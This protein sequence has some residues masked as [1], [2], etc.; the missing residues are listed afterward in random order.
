MSGDIQKEQ[1]PGWG[2][3]L[4]ETFG[5]YGNIQHKIAPQKRSVERALRAPK[6]GN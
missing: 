5:D 1:G 4:Y 3:R 6:A 2:F